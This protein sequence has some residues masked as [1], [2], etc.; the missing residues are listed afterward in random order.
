MLAA[1]T[2]P[3]ALWV[4]K[5]RLRHRTKARISRS[6]WLLVGSTPSVSTKVQS[7]GCVLHH[8]GARAGHV[9]DAGGDCPVENLAHLLLDG[10][11]PRNESAR[12]EL[13]GLVVVPVFEHE[14]RVVEELVDRARP[15]GP[16][17]SENKT[18]FRIR[19]AQQICRRSIDQKVSDV[20]RSLTRIPVSA[21]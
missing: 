10:S 21:P 12:D 18:N 19:W 14:A 2:L 6:A 17:R 1:K 3:R 13:A 5:E 8:V 11:H 4:P 16:S 15:A 7:A 20:A 9:R